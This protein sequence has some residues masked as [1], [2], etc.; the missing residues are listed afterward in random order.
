M[1]Y[2]VGEGDV[3]GG[4]RRQE[5]MFYQECDRRNLQAVRTFTDPEDGSRPGFERLLRTL[6]TSPE[7]L[8]VIVADLDRLGVSPGERVARLLELESRQAKLTALAGGRGDL[9]TRLVAAVEAGRRA[10]PDQE[11]AQ[12]G[13]REKALHG[14]GLGKPPFGYRIGADRRFEVVEAEAET[15]RMIYQMYVNGIP[16]ERG[17]PQRMGLRMIAGRLNGSGRLTRRGVHWSVVT[18]RDILRNR[19]YVGTYIRYDTRVPNNHRALISNDLFTRAQQVRAR[20][21]AAGKRQDDVQVEPEPPF[22]LSGLV[23]C[24]QCGARLIGATRR[25]G[26]V[27]KDRTRVDAVYRYYRCGSRVNQ[28]VCGYHTRRADE[29]ERDVAAALAER[30]GMGMDAA[31]V[32]TPVF[33]DLRR[34]VLRSALY[35]QVHEALA[36][37]HD[38]AALR[39]LAEELLAPPGPA[40]PPDDLPPWLG[41]T[42]ASR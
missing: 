24:G 17:A 31:A 6:E 8:E 21:A 15:V 1:G 33:A 2:F 23:V 32:A 19:A 40:D 39:S 7:P 42:S 18:V 10:T 22:L 25:Q 29:L 20:A 37:H 30:Y 27:R 9:L 12:R 28:S 36:A 26:W 34:Q 5:D 38:V 3:P 11:K 16:D 35:E 41:C 14:Q 4:S 13:L